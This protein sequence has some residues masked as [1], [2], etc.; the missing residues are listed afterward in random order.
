MRHE[1]AAGWPVAIVVAVVCCG[2]AVEVVPLVQTDSSVIIDDLVV[3]G[4]L[5]MKEHIGKRDAGAFFEALPRLGGSVEFVALAVNVNFDRFHR[6]APFRLV[7][8][9]VALLP[10]AGAV[11]VSDIYFFVD[12]NVGCCWKPGI[13]FERLE[14]RHGQGFDQ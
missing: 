8:C 5:L 11:E 4:M 2:L 13:G 7:R 6:L 1:L 9:V 14:T 3:F 12:V 10:Y